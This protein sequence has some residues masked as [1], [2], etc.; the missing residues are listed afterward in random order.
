MR[1]MRLQDNSLIL[2][3]SVLRDMKLQDNSLF[4]ESPVMRDTKLQ[5]NSP[6]S[7]SIVCS[8]TMRQ[9]SITAID[10][11]A[12]PRPRDKHSIFSI[13]SRIYVYLILNS[14][15]NV[16]SSGLTVRNVCIF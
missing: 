8:G 12:Y 14:I 15:E 9:C 1:D 10:R 11:Q 4:L 5:D 16:R 6:S 13:D 7:Q 2:E 3:S